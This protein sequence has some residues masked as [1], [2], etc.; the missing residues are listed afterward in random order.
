[1][2]VEGLGY[3]VSEWDA[4]ITDSSEARCSRFVDSISVSDK[5]VDSL[6]NLGFVG[7]KKVDLP[8]NTELIT[9]SDAWL[10]ILTLTHQEGQFWVAG[11]DSLVVWA[12]VGSKT[13][14]KSWVQS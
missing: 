3:G 13:K 5:L 11:L 7:A 10:R 14:W 1:M 8:L 6:T 12:D 9:G 4:S 2:K